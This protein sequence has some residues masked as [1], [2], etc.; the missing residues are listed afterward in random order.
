MAETT[1]APNETPEQTPEDLEKTLAE[2][3]YSGR[4]TGPRLATVISVIAAVW[5]V[6]QLWIASPFPF[7]FDFGIIVGVPARGIHLG[8][9]FLLCFLMYPASRRLSKRSLPL[10]DIALALV[11]CFCALYLYI[12]YDGLVER[13]GILWIWDVGGHRFPFEALLGGI[14]I[15]LLLEATR[16]SIG[17]PLVIVASVFLVYSVFGQSMP[18]IISHR[19]VSLARLIG[20]HWLTGE[21]IF[22]I[23]IDVSVSFIF[24]FVLFGA[25][26]EQAGAGKYFLDLAFGMVGRYRGGP[27]KAAILA[28]GMTGAISGSSIANVVTTGTFTIPVMVRMGLPATKAGAIE[29][30]ASTNGQIMPPIMGA[31]AFIIAEL[32]G[33]SYFDVIIAAF[34]PAI[35]SYIALLYISHLEALKLGLK[36]LPKSEIP[37]IWPTFV[38]GIHFLIPIVVLVYL[39]MVERWTAGSAV[40]YSIMLLMVII[41]IERV[42][43]ALRTGE[44]AAGVAIKMSL[45]QCYVGMVSGARNMINISVAI[46]AAGIIVGAVSSTGLNNA[47]VGVIEAISGGNVFILLGLTAVLCLILGMGLPTTANYLVVASLLA[48]VLVEL[49]QAAGLVLPLIAVHLFVLYFG[50]M[51]DSTP[52]VCLAAF[53]AAAISRADPIQTGVQSFLYDIRTAVLP[54][55]FIF[56]TEL[57]LIGVESIWHGLLVF[58]VSLLAILCFSSITQRWMLVKVTW[59]EGILL[60]VAMVCFFRPDFVMDQIHPKF[61]VL[62]MK[63]FIAGEARARPGYSIRMHVVRQTDYGDRFKLFRMATPEIKADTLDELYGI[64]LMP[65]ED[66]RF[67]VTDLMP[68]GIAE[69]SGIEFDDLVKAVDVE[70]VGQPSKEWIY[71]I[72]FASLALVIGMQLR[73]RRQQGGDAEPAAAATAATA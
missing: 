32:I 26:L 29:V 11:G 45:N 61:E 12:G 60:A 5:S 48:G 50:L 37:A 14:G 41:I 55:V 68:K 31:A 1:T 42:W 19:G 47:L 17:L 54:F 62:D 64:T 59:V 18:E 51:A 73:R 13:R 34:I 8:F 49:G 67:R 66:G 44:E 9:G 3:E 2:I 56:N 43:R 57:L 69:Q 20:Y 27:A 21:A 65:E 23:P 10:Y 40:F 38:S 53:A 35:I 7:M 63:P 46:A 72:G 4:A 28:S 30:A 36:G 24:L 16:R 70:V 58:I 71:L 33:I 15:V 52:P 22:G 39:L 25:L 6:F